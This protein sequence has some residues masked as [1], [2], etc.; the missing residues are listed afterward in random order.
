MSSMLNPAIS[1][2]RIFELTSE[3][4]AVLFAGAVLTVAGIAGISPDVTTWSAIG[5]GFTALVIGHLCMTAR[6]FV[7]FPDLIAAASCL[8]W[9]VAPWLAAEYPSRMVL[10]HMSL[11]IDEYLRYAVPATIALWVGLHLP[12]S[13]ILSTT[14]VLPETEPLSKPVRRTL[15]AAIVIGLIVDVYSVYVP[16]QLAFLG[17]LIASLRFVGALG[18]MVTKT[19]GWMIRVL[20]VMLHF[21]ATQSAGGGMFYLVVH[22]AGY[23]LLVYGFMKRW[24]MTMAMALLAGIVGLGLLQSV[25]PSFRLS[26][27][28]ERPAGSVE[29]FTR[30]TSMLWER[31]SQGHAIDPNADTGDTLVRF[32]QGWIIARIMTHVPAE[33]PYAAGQT[34]ADAAIFTILPRF[35]FPN[36]REGASTELF[37]RFTGIKL[38]PNTRMGLGVIGELYANF[39][40]LGGVLATLVYG[41]MMGLILLFF[42][43]RA[44]KNPLWWAVA[45][46]ILLPCVEPGFNIEDVSNH[47]V[48]AAVVFLIVWKL[49]PPVQRLLAPPAH[50][51]ADED[52]DDLPSFDDVV[53]DH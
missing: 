15:D 47:I 50:T 53:T 7:A 23:F 37:F 26:L 46:A 44:Q 42:A 41:G 9:I 38:P 25:K 24:R 16:P 43:V 4:W 10:Y 29:A 12:A 18:W 5:L 33:E 36:K 52:F 21:V 20:G 1:R 48:K 3:E 30:L 22:W 11:P 14:W 13:R 28:E 35:L 40:M 27:I 39:G 31:V 32:N 49:C 51:Q 19:P 34:L 17:Y 6:R 2:S 8:Q 45:P